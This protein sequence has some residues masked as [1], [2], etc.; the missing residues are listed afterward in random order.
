MRYTFIS[1]PVDVL[2]HAETVKLFVGAVEAGTKVTH[3]A[4][5]VAKLVRMRSNP[6]LRN[7]VEQSD[8]IGIDGMGIVWG[9][10]L[11]GIPV[12]ERVAGIDLMRSI[13]VECGRRGYRPYFL[14]A[15]AEIVRRAA[16]TVRRDIPGLELAGLHDGYFSEDEERAIAD[17]INASGAHCLFVGMPTPR[18]ERFLAAHRHRIDAPFVMGVGGSFDVIA[19]KVT[20]APGWAR[21]C[22]LEWLH[23]VLQEPRRMV[24]RYAAT[25]AA[26][27][28]LLLRE[29]ALAPLRGRHHRSMS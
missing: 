26:F 8:I 24:G 15:T 5:N 28:L 16:E 27:L 20:R 7:D 18:K 9:A 3:T 13:L 6:V 1:T 4:L 17:A 14:G 2:T 19:G 23:R 12:P 25:N 21:R 11:L 22:G 10:R 29:L